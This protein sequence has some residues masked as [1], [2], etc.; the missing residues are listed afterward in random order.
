MASSP[1]ITSH[2]FHYIGTMFDNATATFVSSKSASLIAAITPMAIAGIGL[3]ITTYG[4]LIMAG[5]IQEPFKDFVFKCA[6]IIFI[7]AF[8][9]NTANYLHY[10]VEAINGLQSGLSSALGTGTGAASIYDQLD[11]TL[12]KS[13]RIFQKCMEK[14]QDASWYDIATVIRW[15]SIGAL[16]IVATLAV[17]LVGGFIIITASILLKVMLAIGP[18]FIMCLFWPVTARFFESWL[19]QTLAYVL[20][21]VSVAIV[22]AL[23]ENIF[24][25]IVDHADVTAADSNGLIMGIE[26]V[27]VGYILYR[28][29]IEVVGSMASIAGGVSMAV[30]TLA[31]M[32]SATSAPLRA[33]R[34]AKNVGGA[35]R[36][37]VD[38]MT[39]RRDLQSGMMSTAR[40]SNHMVAGNTAWNPAYRQHLKQ[41]LGRNWG[42]AR[43]GSVNKD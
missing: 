12:T 25:R 2:I 36:N 29:M 26:I 43:G 10:V 9:L 32:A 31:N 1:L 8:A 7:A 14:A 20:K 27:I 18:L 42:R 17:V 16:I 22:L 23:A 33:A 38:P 11:Q 6:K 28:V 39:T 5:K 35:A 3:F 40:R 19:G 4:Y 15:Y 30:M 13:F 37:V 41:N 21:I 34:A 24:G